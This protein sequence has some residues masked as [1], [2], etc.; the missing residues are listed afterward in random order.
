MV[1]KNARWVFL[2]SGGYVTK[3]YVHPIIYFSNQTRPNRRFC[4]KKKL[5]KILTNFDVIIKQWIS[6]C[7]FSSI[8][9]IWC[10]EKSLRNICAYIIFAIEKQF[11]E[12][13]WSSLSCDVFDLNKNDLFL[14][15]YC[16]W[17]ILE[18]LFIILKYN[19]FCGWCY[20]N[21]F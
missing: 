5:P 9:V 18:E 1:L 21:C 13:R 16:F 15:E 20:F 3:N 10:G 17:A 11:V 7:V 12:M 19:L 6:M 4:K 8:N 14:Y 2:V